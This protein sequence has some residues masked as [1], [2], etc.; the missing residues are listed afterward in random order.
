MDLCLQRNQTMVNRANLYTKKEKF[1]NQ[2]IC[3]AKIII[4]VTYGGSLTLM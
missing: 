1:Q 3:Y 2:I 4:I